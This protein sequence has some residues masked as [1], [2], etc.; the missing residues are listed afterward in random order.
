MS[1][2]WHGVIATA[3]MWT[4]LLIG[5]AAVALFLTGR[6]GVFPVESGEVSHDSRYVVLKLPIRLLLLIL[7]LTAGVLLG[8][9]G[10]ILK[11]QILTVEETARNFPETM[12]PF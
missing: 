9:T 12:G 2:Q 3:L 1:F 5:L 7:P 10:T 11:K 8:V 4:G 6:F